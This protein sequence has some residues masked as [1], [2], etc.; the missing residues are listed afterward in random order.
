MVSRLCP[1]VA[2]KGWVLGPMAEFQ[3]WIIRLDP[4]VGFHGWIPRLGPMARSQGWVQVF[5]IR[6]HLKIEAQG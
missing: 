3:D 6:L 1:N 4:K 2:S 5:V